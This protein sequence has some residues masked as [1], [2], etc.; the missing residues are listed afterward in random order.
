MADLVWIKWYAT[1]L[2]QDSLAAEVA[3]VAPLALRYGA[4][5]YAVQIDNDDRYR[6]TQMAWFTNKTDWYRYWDGPE[7]LEFRARNSGRF[8]IPV[9]YTWQDEIA[10]GALG[11]EVPAAENGAPNG[12]N[13]APNGGPTSSAPTPAAPPVR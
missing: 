4:T 8:Q 11:P 12:R 7:M 13:G 1:V 6:V 10:A 5:Q 9:T 2:R 3:A